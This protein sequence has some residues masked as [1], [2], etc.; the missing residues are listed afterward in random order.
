MSSQEIEPTN[1]NTNPNPQANG[2]NEE[3]QTYGTGATGAI[4][5]AAL[6]RQQQRLQLQV[7]RYQQMAQRA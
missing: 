3:T 4:P 1:E 5:P 7:E 2:A 6:S